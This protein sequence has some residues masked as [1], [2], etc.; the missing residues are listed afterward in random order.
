MTLVMDFKLIK[1]LMKLKLHM[2]LTLEYIQLKL[3]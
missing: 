1:N 3:E 2:N